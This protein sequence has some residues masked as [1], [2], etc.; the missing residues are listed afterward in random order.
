M[1]GHHNRP[2]SSVVFEE[3]GRNLFR[4]YLQISQ[5]W[6]IVYFVGGGAGWGVNSPFN[7][8]LT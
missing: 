1:M 4:Q 8:A 7:A 2:S 6:I 5:I 3:K